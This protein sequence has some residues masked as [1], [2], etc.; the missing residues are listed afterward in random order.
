MLTFVAAVS[1]ALVGSFLCSIM[2][3]VLLSLGTADVEA[4]DRQ[5]KRAGRLLKGFK[6]RIDIPIAA[7]LIVNTVAH[8][9][10]A[11]VAGATYE[12]AFNEETLWLF[13][14]VFTVAILLFTEIIPKTLGVVYARRLASP[15]AYLIQI[16]TVIL[17]PLVKTTEL[18]S[19]S[20]RGSKEDPATS[21]EEI[22]LLAT[23]GRREG[24]VG[25]RTAGM[26]VGATRLSQLRAYDVMVPRQDVVFLSGKRSEAENLEV[27]RNSRHSRLP[28]SSSG[29]LDQVTGIVLVKEL[30]YERDANPNEPIDWQRLMQEPLVVSEGTP[31]N[32]LLRTFQEQRRHMAMVVDEY[33]NV[34]GIVTLED[35]LEEI[36]GEIVDESDQEDEAIWPQDDGSLEVIAS[37]E[38][39]NVG[40]HLGFDWL[41]EGDV[42][43]A[44][45][46][47]SELLGRIPQRG[48]S[49]EWNGYRL[50]VLAASPRRAERIRVVRTEPPGE[51]EETETK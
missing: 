46:L 7:I 18:I 2:E 35:V 48:D 32:S 30:Y 14:A 4:L 41:S 50:E 45:G 28:Y 10:G 22:R 9:V 29:D 8:T 31:L 39:R 3:S 25:P 33:G 1:L 34:E 38:M 24:V 16:L 23:L 15:V 43:S 11:S 27:I 19:R 42:T 20:L 21:I 26:I 51:T 17:L 12:N 6:N 37:V 13:T 40:R 49:A 44:G 5:G 36:V 47:V